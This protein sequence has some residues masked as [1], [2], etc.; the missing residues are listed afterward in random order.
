MNT[1]WGGA[2][3]AFFCNVTINYL[4]PRLCLIDWGFRI[5]VR[6]FFDGLDFGFKVRLRRINLMKIEG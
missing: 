4:I 3:Q 1:T 6:R 5:L 2:I